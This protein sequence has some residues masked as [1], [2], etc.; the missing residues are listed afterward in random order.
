[1]ALVKCGITLYE[2]KSITGPTK[3]SLFGSRTASLH[4]KAC[5]ADRKMSFV[6]SFNL[7]P[8]SKSINTEMGTI[9]ESNSLSNELAELLQAQMHGSYRLAS[10]NGRIVWLEDDGANP[11]VHI[12]EPHSP[13]T[14]R[15]GAW[16]VGLLPIESQL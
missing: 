3:I 2:Q 4:T 11:T 13:L 15:M 6:G 10:Q 16:L 5:V 9:F 7:D 1:M 14:R 8:R 12:T